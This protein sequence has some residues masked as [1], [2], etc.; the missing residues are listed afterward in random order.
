MRSFSDML[1]IAGGSVILAFL[2]APARAHDAPKGWPY[3]FECCAGFD[4]RPVNHSQ[5][6][7]R[8]TERSGG[9][10]IS[11]TGEWIAANDR[12]IRVSPDGEYHWCSASGLATGKTICL[13]VPPSSF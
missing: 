11:T 9:Y 8:V 10:V 4:C 7:I 6:D 13:F 1:Y 12:K 3:P 5:T 2:P